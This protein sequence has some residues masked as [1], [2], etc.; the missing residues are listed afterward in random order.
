M[1]TLSE[2]KLSKKIKLLNAAYDLFLE[3]GV[4]TTAIDEIVKQA[5]VAK[6]TFYLYFHD[7]YD[8]L[9]EIVLRKGQSVFLGAF[10]MLEKANADK[11]MPL[12]E[13]IWLFTDNIIDYMTAHKELVALIKK[14]LPA[15]LELL[16]DD[17]NNEMD[18]QLDGLFHLFSEHGYPR[19]ETKKLIYL[20]SNMI[21]STC[22]D[23]ILY[24]K[25]YSIE[26]LRPQI[27][28][29]INKLTI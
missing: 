25:P 9:D 19:D 26:E 14:N 13:Q 12:N 21:S 3:K 6:G 11:T 24:S 4:N 17:E 18:P 23:A 8:L 27:H 22:C 29:V 5:G 16:L 7:K 15:C 10:S 28:I 2:K 20:I 1:S